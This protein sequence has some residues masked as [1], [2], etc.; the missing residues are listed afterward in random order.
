M[1]QRGVNK[2]ILLGTLG[3]K[4]ELKYAANGNP[5][6][7]FSMATSEE[8][9][10]KQTGQKQEKTEWH[11]IVIYGRLAEIAGEY[12]D[13]GRQVYIEGKLQTRKWQDQN[14]Q[15]RFMTEIVVNGFDGQM[16]MIG[17][18]GGN[19]GNNAQPQRTDFNQ[20]NF[21]NSFNQSPQN[22]APMGAGQAVQPQR[23]PAYVANDFDEDDV[24]SLT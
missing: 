15:D 8:W 9:N 5:I 18:N 10:D 13:K 24:L 20:D 6:C 7:T 12:L 3:A 22:V 23:A 16:Q 1:G 17:G 11:R 14:G 21:A 19:S 2:C 4:P